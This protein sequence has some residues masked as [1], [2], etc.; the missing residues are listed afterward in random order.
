VTRAFTGR[1]ARSVRNRFIAEYEHSGQESLVWP[2]QRVAAQ[3]Q[4]QSDYYLLLA[5]QGLRMAT[6]AD[7]SAAEIVADIVTQAQAEIAHLTQL[8][9]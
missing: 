5:G 7:Q 1:A 6:R 9:S 3:A 4:E 2:L 8:L